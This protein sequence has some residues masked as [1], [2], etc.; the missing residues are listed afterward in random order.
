MKWNLYEDSN[1]KQIY[2]MKHFASKRL[3]ESKLLNDAKNVW[4]Y[5]AVSSFD[6]QAKY[7]E[8][9]GFKYFRLWHTLKAVVTFKIRELRELKKPYQDH[10]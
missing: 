7:A 3:T 10:L 8:Y 4:S 6:A 5:E 1:G 2:V 9:L